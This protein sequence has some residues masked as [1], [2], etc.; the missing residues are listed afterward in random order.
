MKR[1]L[2]LVDDSPI[3]AAVA[4]TAA[5]IARINSLELDLLTFVEPGDVTERFTP[6]L[7]EAQPPWRPRRSTSPIRSGLR[8]E[9]ADES[10]AVVIVGASST[11]DKRDG[12]GHIARLIAT[13]SARPLVLVP[14]FAAPLVGEDLR[15][16]L[17][18][19]GHR[20]TTDSV[21][22]A[23]EELFAPIGTV[24][25]LHV[26]GQATIPMFVSSDED[27][28]VIAEEFAARHTTP[29]A[30]GAT[31]PRLGLG[32]PADEIVASIEREHADAVILCWKQHLES[33]RANVVRRL[34]MDGRTVVVLVP[35]R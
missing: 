6:A 30:Q 24:V 15:F 2:G 10:V 33:G 12:L 35:V 8:V 27:R 3:A 20:P 25:P 18:L 16:L 13:T 34:L 22:R 9:L 5:Q 29:I 32:E 11:G 21:M 26:F 1:V 14:P 17:P 31:L 19:D 28:S 23:V 7:D 4:A